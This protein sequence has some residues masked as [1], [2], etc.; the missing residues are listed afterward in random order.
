MEHYS[1]TILKILTSQVNAL[2]K[3]FKVYD[4]ICTLHRN[5]EILIPTVDSLDIV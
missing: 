3:A 5:V 2:L 1:E 4:E